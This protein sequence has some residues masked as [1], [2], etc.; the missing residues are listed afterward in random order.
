MRDR[1]EELALLIRTLR[2]AGIRLTQQRI[3][4]YLEVLRSRGHPSAGEVYSQVR[5][6]LP[7]ISL[8]TVYRNLWKLSE[9]G[10]ISPL[11]TSGGGVRFDS[12]VEHHHHFICAKCGE[13]FDFENAS[14]D[15]IPVPDNVHAL[16][17]VWDAHM[18]IRGICSKCLEEDTRF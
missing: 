9:L 13:T 8:D 17:R 4:V 1:N 7:S 10:L 3:E 5:K 14:L 12:K 11:T 15:S 18:E 2:S 16:G 6:R